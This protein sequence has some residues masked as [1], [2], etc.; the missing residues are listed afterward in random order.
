MINYS[1]EERLDWIYSNYYETGK[2]VKVVEKNES[3]KAEVLFNSN[4]ELL[5]ICLSEDNRLKYLKTANVADGTV[6]EFVN[7]SEIILHIAECKR[8]IN[9][10]N[11][12]KVKLQFRGGIQ[13]S[14]G[15]CGVLNKSVSKVVFYTAFR[16]DKLN[17][18]NTTNPILLKATLGT[19]EKTSAIDW[20]QTKISILDREFEHIKIQLDSD[21]KGQ[22]KL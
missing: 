15:L 9:T 8:T 13:N 4:N 17:T 2:Q 6:C 5:A 11:W 3:G 14:Y 22:L 21:G 1:F 18:R 16:E 12:E 19:K 7:E 10:K 20:N